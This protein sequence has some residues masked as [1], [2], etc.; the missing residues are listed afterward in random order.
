[1]PEANR[2]R[3]PSSGRWATSTP[4]RTQRLTIRIVPRQSRPFDLAVRWE[5]KPIASQAMIEV[6]EPKL[7]LKLEGPREV[8]YGKKELYRLK[9]SN[10]GNGNAENVAI[11]LTPIGTGENVPASHKV[12]LLPAGEEK[13][14]DVELTARQAGTLT[15]Q[16]EAR[17][18][19]GVRTDLAEKVLVH[20]AALKLDIDGPK[21]QFV[22]AVANYV[23]RVRNTGT[24]PARNIHLSIALPSGAKYLSGIEGARRSAAQNKLEWTLE[25]S[26]PTWSRVSR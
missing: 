19:G 6:Q 16:A 22:G 21:V 11:V 12:G 14:L 15:I 26:A 4:S 17:A 3:A 20:R 24:A 2:R 18:D 1:M 7:S 23:V 13:S 25:R 10:T 9:L 8:H 5:S